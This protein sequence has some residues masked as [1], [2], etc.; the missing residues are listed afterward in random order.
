MK[1]VPIGN[2]E[3]PAKGSFKIGPFGSSLKKSELT[4]TGIPV[5]GIEDVLR[6]EFRPPFR[7]F[8]SEKKFDELRKFNVQKG[9]VLVTTMGTVGRAAV[10]DE[11]VGHMIIDS[12]LFRMRLDQ[13]KVYPLYLAYVL[14]HDPGLKRQLEMQQRGA[15][16]AGLNTSI[17]KECLVPLP[18]LSVQRQITAVLVQA[19]RLRR[20]RRYAL[21]LSDSY[22]QSVFLEMFG[23][24]ATNPKGWEALTVSDVITSSQ[25][26]TSE[27]SN[28]L[29]Q[30]YPVL[31][32]GNIT[33]SGQVDLTNISY[34]ELPESE[35]NKLRL[36]HGD[37]IF[38]RTNSTELVGKTA[39]WKYDMQAVLASYLV[40]L[41]TDKRVH[42]DYFSQLLNTPY[43]KK[44][45]QERCKK[46]VGQSNISPTLLKEFPFLLPPYSLQQKFARAVDGQ[47]RL[48]LQQLEALRQSEHLFQSLLHQF[49]YA[50]NHTEEVQ[51]SVLA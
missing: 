27:R 39:P 5:V 1:Y 20:L 48:R 51:R 49:F 33:Y 24:P 38:N 9:D 16:M 50:H 34:V 30:G 6:Q 31:G 12:H 41:K 47:E 43:Y 19:D 15:I 2:L 35:F 13:S 29:G 17:L 45:M 14:N 40:K 4:D 28:S 32:M 44:M 26:G 46:A 10:V 36:E 37:I 42:P 18:R 8:I 25:Y 23:D 22:L 21:E 3:H 11:E 7:R